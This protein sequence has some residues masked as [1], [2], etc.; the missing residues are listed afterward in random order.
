MIWIPIVLALGL[1][2]AF[3]L[4][5]WGTRWGSTPAERARRM[6][7][8]EWLEGGPRARVAMTRGVSIEAPPER[9]WPWIAQ[10][11][12]GAGWYSIDALDNGRRVSAWHIVSWIPAPRLGDA[13]AIGYVRHIDT[14]GSLAWWTGEG[15]FS[16]AQVRLVTCFRLEAA[17]QGTRLISRMSADAAGATAQLALWTF[18]VLDSIMARRQLLGIRARVDHAETEREAPKDPET[19]ARDQYQYYEVLYAAGGSAGVAGKEQGA[20][21]RQSAI[22]DGIL[23]DPEGASPDSEAEGAV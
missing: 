12:R 14:G 18:R 9:V 7:G 17:G 2:G 21:W 15:H 4:L 20:R 23:E 16:G 8:D 22:E 3:L 1:T 13:T 6:P 10:L 19:G 5:R 11:G